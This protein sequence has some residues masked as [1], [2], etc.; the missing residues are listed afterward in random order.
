M[1]NLKINVLGYVPYSFKDKETGN[2]V[3]GLS[4]WFTEEKA[5]NDDYG[6]GFIP[7]KIT[8]PYEY[9]NILQGISFPYSAEPKF[10]TRFT[11]KGPKTEISEL[12]FKDPIK[13]IIDKINK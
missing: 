3:S 9:K 2:L 1:E 7:R 5:Q 13:F 8:M 6:V 11:S 4:V 12:D 10:S